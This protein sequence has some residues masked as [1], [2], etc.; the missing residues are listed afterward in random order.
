LTADDFVTS[1]RGAAGSGDWST[2]Y[3]Y[4]FSVADA[5]SM[6][7]SQVMIDALSDASGARY[8]YALDHPI[9][10]AEP[11]RP[12]RRLTGERGSSGGWLRGLQSSGNSS[13][14]SGSGGN[15]TVG[16][17]VDTRVFVQ[18]APVSYVNATAV[19]SWATGIVSRNVSSLLTAFLDSP[20][21]GARLGVN[22]T[23]VGWSANAVELNV[24]PSIAILPDPSPAVTVLPDGRIAF[25]NLALAGIVGA[26]CVG[27]VV[28]TVFCYAFVVYLRKSKAVKPAAPPGAAPTA[29]GTPA[30][31]EGA[32]VP[33]PSD[34][35]GLPRTGSA[36]S[37]SVPPPA[38]DGGGESGGGAGVV[39]ASSTAVGAMQAAGD[40]VGTPGAPGAVVRS[41][42]GRGKRGMRLD[43]E[44][45]SD[46]SHT[47][48]VTGETGVAA[49]PVTS[50]A[51]TVTRIGP[52]GSVSAVAGSNAAFNKVAAAA[53]IAV[54]NRILPIIMSPQPSTT[55]ASTAAASVQ[56]GH[57]SS[58]STAALQPGRT[59]VPSGSA[60]RRMA[61]SVGGS[62]DGGSGSGSGS[63]IGSV[64]ERG[65]TPSNVQVSA[66]V[67]VGVCVCPG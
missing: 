37:A 55:A 10:L 5:L 31:G 45:G 66:G 48:S 28:A 11:P 15:V 27:S 61:S 52:N 58:P 42:K 6:L 67:H 4:R 17:R 59:R 57:K 32:A 38:A 20:V 26:A 30:G 8:A 44:A 34:S 54:G 18:P 25:S 53:S 64:D 22:S 50:I 39:G 33:P 47:G 9:N 40:N 56:A 16:L 35:S 65:V 1:G 62:E 36:F 3:A 60:A 46:E 29:V 43:M 2:A 7:V 49:P 14:S 19:T 24:P 12:A 51:G 23:T 21:G 41:G 13:S 63:G